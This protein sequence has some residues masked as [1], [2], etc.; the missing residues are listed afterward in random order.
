MSETRLTAKDLNDRIAEVTSK[1]VADARE[2]FL[3]KLEEVKNEKTTNYG[4][5]LV[6]GPPGGAKQ[7]RDE[8]GMLAARYIATLG[9]SVL[10]ARKGHVISAVDIASKRYGDHDAVT[11]ALAA[12]DFDSGGALVPEEISS[13]IIELLRATS[14]FM[15]LNPIV[16]PMSSGIL[17][18]PKLTGGATAAYVGENEAANKTEQTFGQVRLTAKKLTALVPVSNDFLRRSDPAGNQIIRDDSVASIAE[19]MDQAFIRD[20]GSENAPQGIRYQ[21]P[22]AHAIAANATINLANVTTDLGKLWL[23]LAE[24]NVKFR[25]PGWMFAPR[26]LNYLMNV[27]DTNGNFAFRA[28]LLAGNL[29]GYPYGY[30][31]SIPVNLGGGSDESEVYLVD[32]ADVVVGETMGLEVSVSTEASYTDGGSQKSAFELDQSVVRAIVEHD[33]KM[34][35]AES[36]AC[37]TAVKWT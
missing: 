9:Q 2:E 30:T 35:H 4:D 13:D 14:V 3:A 31:T 22:S 5:Q 24:D 20:V 18:M 7:P 17:R 21:I 32:F 36:G 27:R 34:R 16:A 12:T 29:W 23:A 10:S 25:R 8:K 19:R 1:A 6:G 33:M 28:E 11:K 15:K 37:L 26:T